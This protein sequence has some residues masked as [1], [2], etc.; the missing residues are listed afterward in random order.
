MRE[1][2][3]ELLIRDPGPDGHGFRIETVPSGPVY[4]GY[5]PKRVD[6]GMYESASELSPVDGKR[7]YLLKAAGSDKYLALTEREHFLWEQMDGV[8]DIKDIASLYFFEFGSLDF[9]GVR[10]LLH[11]L[12]EAGLVK[13]TPASR[14]RVAADRSEGALAR[15][16]RRLT[17]LLEFRIEDA[18]GWVTRLY[19]GGGYMLVSKYAMAFYALISLLGITAFGRFERLGMFP[20]ELFFSHPLAVIAVVISSFYPVMA[21]HELFHALACK[22]RGRK[23]SGFGFAFWDGFYP[24][25]YTDVSDIYLSP[26]RERLFVSLAGPLSTTAIASVFFLPAL[27]FPEAAVSDTFYEVGRLNLLVGM[28]ALYPFQFI[29]MDGYYILVDILG[30]PGLRERS[31][32]FVKGLPGFVRSGKPFTYAE[33]VMTGYVVMCVLSIAALF[34]LVA[35]ATAA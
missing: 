19:E 3:L 8:R 2:K 27:M 4:A 35:A 10:A 33:A 32:A 15:A 12:S 11:R 21:A 23:V 5:R 7:Y 22:G 14:L 6:E 24:S 30:F 18:D 31:F 9:S 1:S 13:L 28:V 16:F 26:R 34:L 17:G 20:Y 29:K 25:F